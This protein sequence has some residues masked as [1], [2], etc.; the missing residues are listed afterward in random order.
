MHSFDFVC[1]GAGGGPNEAD[2][3]A[4]LLKTSE[5]HWEDGIIAVEAGS[6]IGA[7]TTILDRKLDTFHDFKLSLD[8]NTPS[9]IRAAQIY[10]C[11]HHLD[12]VLSLVLSAGSLST[13]PSLHQ[14]PFKR[15]RIVG[16]KEVLDDLSTMIFSDRIWPNLASWSAESTVPDYLYL[17]DP[18]ST[19]RPTT[20]VL[21]DTAPGM[22]PRNQYHPINSVV[23]V[24]AMPISHGQC[25]TN[26]S[27]APAGTYTSTAFF[28]R[29]NTTHKQFLFFGDVEPD[30]L[31][32][33]PLTKEVWDVAA[34]FVNTILQGGQKQ[35][36]SIFIECS[37]PSARADNELFGHLN[38]QH[39][40][41]EMKVLASSIRK[42]RSSSLPSLPKSDGGTVGVLTNAEMNPTE[43][44]KKRRRL[45]LFKRHS[46]EKSI[47]SRVSDASIASGGAGVQPSGSAQIPILP[48]TDLRDAL[49]GVKLYLMHFKA[50]MQ[51]SQ[52]V[53]NGKL[54]QR[55]AEEVRELVAKEGLGLEVFAMEQ[56]MRITI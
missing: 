22:D 51:P 14:A 34:T 9:S 20:K 21:K 40:L 25:R 15:R 2:L 28:I 7:L 47:A 38:P 12:H 5:S 52:G 43:T 36:D 49:K 8:T 54:T 55:I 17:Y 37:W 4:Y 18:I 31:A 35:L 29:H 13:P 27:H 39:L 48:E 24:L 41:Q 10:S 56:G 23:S 16:T 3:S 46:R 32:T 53:R 42:M 1:L 30:S 44:T 50:P 33:S 11:I 6:G 26:H 19:S 45:T